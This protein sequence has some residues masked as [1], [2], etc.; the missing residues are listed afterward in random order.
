M[1][2]RINEANHKR[3]FG[4]YISPSAKEEEFGEALNYLSSQMTFHQQSEPILL[5]D[6]NSDP[7]YPKKWA[8]LQTFL[9]G[10]RLE[11]SNEEKTHSR[12]GCCSRRLDLV[13]A[14]EKLKTCTVK[15]LVKTDHSPVVVDMAAYGLRRPKAAPKKASAKEIIATLED[16]DSSKA[17]K[18]NNLQ[19]TLEEPS[20]IAKTEAKKPDHIFESLTKA[21]SRNGDDDGMIRRK[22]KDAIEKKKQERWGIALSNAISRKRYDLLT[23]IL[24]KGK[25]AQNWI[26][27][28]ELQKYISDL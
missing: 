26:D 22:L 25:K 18:T 2:T 14:R 6:F 9:S 20:K 10:N 15:G 5:G 27:D 4:V 23:S 19:A 17:N 8:R 11:I 16:Q 13:I 21:I 1:E 12:N 3:I 24:R 28:N 7:I